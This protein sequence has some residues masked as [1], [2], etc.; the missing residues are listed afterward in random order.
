MCIPWPSCL[1]LPICREHWHECDT[2]LCII[3]IPVLGLLNNPQ[4]YIKGTRLEGTNRVIHRNSFLRW[5]FFI[6]M[7]LTTPSP[8]LCRPLL[9]QLRILTS[10]SV[11]SLEQ[12]FSLRCL[13][14][15]ILVYFILKLPSHTPSLRKAREGTHHRKW[16]RN[17]SRSFGTGFKCPRV[18]IH[19]LMGDC[20]G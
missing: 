8:C 12:P 19:T 14:T 20:T 11:P 6:T 5:M 16:D 9:S 10:E 1:I 18:F 13:F 17:Q 2:H 7:P 4:I 15:T 3:N